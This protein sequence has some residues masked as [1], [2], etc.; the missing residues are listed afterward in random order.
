MLCN[1]NFKGIEWDMQM[2]QRLSETISHT[3]GLGQF[4]PPV[5]F[6][7]D[8][9]SPLHAAACSY[10]Y[11]LYS[12]INYGV[13]CRDTRNAADVHA[14]LNQEFQD[15]LT[16]YGKLFGVDAGELNWTDRSEGRRM[17]NSELVLRCWN[18]LY[19]A[20]RLSLTQLE[21]ALVGGPEEMRT[22]LSY[23]T[24]IT[25]LY[26][27]K[28]SPALAGRDLF[29]ELV[30]R[31][32]LGD[33]EFQDLRERNPTEEH[34]SCDYCGEEMAKRL[35]CS[36]CKVAL[37]CSRDHQRE[38]FKRHKTLCLQYEARNREN[39]EDNDGVD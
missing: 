29:K 15:Q 16:D 10:S 14:P 9:H 37:Y 18:C 34:L 33:V 32:C 21:C 19:F 6:G 2:Y 5:A 24:I 7:D 39:Q 4:A 38:D 36:R 1:S 20:Q 25:G 31:K 13:L 35:Q 17:S 11:Q 3:Y 30:K 27:M 8:R 28:D 23:S 26:M 22:L 12:L